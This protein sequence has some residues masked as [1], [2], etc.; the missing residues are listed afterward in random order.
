MKEQ[1]STVEI[2]SRVSPLLLHKEVPA[3][4]IELHAQEQ[5]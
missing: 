2:G 1:Q 5:I 4:D 3:Q